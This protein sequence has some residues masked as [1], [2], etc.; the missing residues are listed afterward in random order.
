MTLLLASIRSGS[1]SRAVLDAGLEIPHW[2][3]LPDSPLPREQDPEPSQPK[4]G[5]QRAIELEQKFVREEVWPALGD[6]T[7]ALIRSQHG[8]LAST[9][10]TALPT[11]KATRL[12]AQPF[13]VFLCRRLHLLLPLSMRTCQCGRQ[14]D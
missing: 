7:K 9:S 12:E 5:W 8:P 1:A 3:V 6:N 11:S 14:L 10:L 13:R 2:Q 4:A